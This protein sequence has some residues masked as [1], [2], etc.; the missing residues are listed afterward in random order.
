M[1]ANYTPTYK[2]KSILKIQKL[3]ER[4]YFLSISTLRRALTTKKIDTVIMQRSSR[5]INTIAIL[6]IN[7]DHVTFQNDLIA[8]LNRQDHRANLKPKQGLRY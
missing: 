6:T 3:S 8:L 2:I 7:C 1:V 4:I 5:G